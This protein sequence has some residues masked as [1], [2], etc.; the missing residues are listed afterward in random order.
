MSKIYQN[1]WA[2]YETYFVPR[3]PVRTRK[4]E[5]EALGGYIIANVEGVWLCRKG[6]YYLS[7]LK[8]DEHFP[9]VGKVEIDVFE[10]VMDTILDALGK[11][12]RA[13]E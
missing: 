3:Y 10:Y 4:G 8:D 1:K 7:T 2:G 6:S 13:K 12:E 5:S 11:G 9:V